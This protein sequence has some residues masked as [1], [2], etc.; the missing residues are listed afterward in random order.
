MRFL[1]LFEGLM[2]QWVCFRFWSTW[3]DCWRNWMNRFYLLFL[4]VIVDI[5]CITIT[6][7]CL[8]SIKILSRVII[9]IRF[10]FGWIAL[11]IYCFH[12][13][14]Q[15]NTF[16]QVIYKLLSFLSILKYFFLNVS[17]MRVGF[18]RGAWHSC[19]YLRNTW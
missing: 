13:F 3:S 19:R 5:R 8:L 1:R 4:V 12:W 17:F 9:W 16:L 15:E 10:V 14:L 6:C 18:F 7:K 2:L 11:D